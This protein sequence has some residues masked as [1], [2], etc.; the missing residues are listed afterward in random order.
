VNVRLRDV[1]A[2]AT[3][4]EQTTGK[5]FGVAQD[6]PFEPVAV[7]P[8]DVRDYRAYLQAVRGFKPNTVNRSL[9]SLSTFFRFCQDTGLV[10]TN[11]CRAVRAVGQQQRPPRWLSRQAQGALRRAISEDLQLAELKA[12]VAGDSHH[13]RPAPYFRQEPGGRGLAAHRGG[14]AAGPRPAEHHRRLHSA[15]PGR[16]AP[17]GGGSGL[18]R[19]M[20]WAQQQQAMTDLHP[21]NTEKG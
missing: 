6:K 17:G 19:T 21:V 11:P 10:A 3:W 5:P 7:T 15:R 12:Q 16:P 18:G 4:F 8:L 13:A 20:I 14:G 1:T 2:F 9:T